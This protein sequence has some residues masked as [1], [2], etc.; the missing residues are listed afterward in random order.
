MKKK[1]ISSKNLIHNLEVTWTRKSS[2]FPLE[3][4]VQFFNPFLICCSKLVT[5][6][7]GIF[8]LST[9]WPLN[10]CCVW[11][12]KK[13]FER[14]LVSLQLLQLCTS[15]KITLPHRLP[16]QCNMSDFLPLLQWIVLRLKI[17]IKINNL[18]KRV[19]HLGKSTGSLWKKHKITSIG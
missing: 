8:T 13:D 12:R 9:F 7:N 14:F 2:V 4:V 17:K 5:L 16:N 15:A 10:I 18:A 19:L 1:K 6:R 11:K 3:I